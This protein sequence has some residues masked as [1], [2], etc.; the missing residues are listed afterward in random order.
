M[1]FAETAFAVGRAEKVM[2]Q[3]RRSQALQLVALHQPVQ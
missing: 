1:S 2:L 3:S